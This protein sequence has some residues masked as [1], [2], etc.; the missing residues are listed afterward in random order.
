M[1]G[2][3]VSPA[4]TVTFQELEIETTTSSQLQD[5]NKTREIDSATTL[6]SKETT[7]TQAAEPNLQTTNTTQTNNQPDTTNR[8]ETT[9]QSETTLSINLDEDVFSWIEKPTIYATAGDIEL[10]YPAV[11]VEV[12]GFHESNHDGA[13][14]QTGSGNLTQFQ[15]LESRGRITD[16]SSAA[17]IVIKPETEIVAP[18]SGTIKRSGTYTLYCKHI[19]SYAVIEPENKPGFEVKVLHITDLQIQTGEYVEAGTTV[20]AS[21]ATQLPFESQVDKHSSKP[22]LPHVHIEVIDLSIPDIPTP[23]GG[24]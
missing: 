15:T 8:S 11:W 18:I 23:G 5:T 24:C 10:F 22:A 16:R 13:Q 17:D 14:Q 19:D 3:S 12:V 4:Q 21:K 9:V 1:T 7:T 20:I 2:C 6:L